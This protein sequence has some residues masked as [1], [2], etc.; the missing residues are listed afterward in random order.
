MIVPDGG[1]V[2]FIPGVVVTLE[3]GLDAVATYVSSEGYSL[4]GDATRTC[5][6][7]M[8][9]GMEQNQHACVSVLMPLKKACMYT[10]NA[11]LFHV[12]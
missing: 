4:V 1:Q 10:C 12:L 11:L 8:A 7:I 9:S 3:T 5:Q 2:T 6:P